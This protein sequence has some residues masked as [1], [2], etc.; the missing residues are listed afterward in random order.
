MLAR[1]HWLPLLL[2]TVG[3]VASATVLARRYQVEGQNRAVEL[4]LDY[5]DVRA[6]AAATGR[7][8][9]VVLQGFREVGVTGLAISELTLEELEENGDIALTPLVAT[10]DLP[11]RWHAVIP[12]ERTFARV[13][14]HLQWKAPGAQ[15][16]EDPEA[17]GVFFQGPTGQSLFVPATWADLREVP[18]GLDEGA[19]TVGRAA[20][21]DIVARVANFRSATPASIR[22]SLGQAR[23]LG[24][25][26]VIFAGEDVMGHRGLIDDT[27]A[28][29][30]EHGLNYGSVEFGRQRGDAKLALLAPE[31]VI[32]V[33]SISSG[34]LVRLAPNTAIQRY[35]RAV[36]ERNIRLAYL[37]LPPA[38]TSDSLKDARSYAYLISQ[39]LTH[40]GYGMRPARP[41]E[42]MWEAGHV[43]IML[44]PML[45]ALGIG[46][47]AALLLASLAPL[48]HNVQA[49]ATIVLAVLSA[50]AVAA[51]PEQGRQLVALLAAVTF[52]TLGFAALIQPF[53]AFEDDHHDLVRDRGEALPTALNEF[54]MLSLVTG[55]GALLV[56]GL[57][58][59][60][61]FML[62]TKSFVGVKV[63]HALPWLVIGMIYTLG[64]TAAHADLPAERR[65]IKARL[66]KALHTPLLS[67]H[68]V[69]TVVTLVAVL[70]VIARSGNDPGVGVSDLEVRFRNLLE[71]LGARPRTKEFLIGHPALALA[72]AMGVLPRWRRWG[73]PFLFFGAIG[74]VSMLNTFCHLHSPLALSMLRTGIGLVF[75]LGIGVALILALIWWDRRLSAAEAHQR[76]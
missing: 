33:H 51:L 24:S 6:L 10:G 45:I 41:F 49:A 25:S 32:R 68:V 12:D 63:A 76:P 72:L 16:R 1:Y 7:P 46:A 17:E 44:L 9:A 50:G 30:R 71:G 2:L 36:K 65:G 62:K 35:I 73:L 18:V 75:G 5:A 64:L 57:L 4:C 43:G 42:P 20:D 58:S 61:P 14:E 13:A 8:L 54:L 55:V 70:L 26:T 53:G 22:W 19:A 37:R 74:Q 66:K 67:W 3:L 31:L 11:R 56:A 21:L 23:A 69:A 27:V 28:A 47:G 15:P 29:L 60:L 59:D 48:G 40:A 52:P 38:P 34:E 39:G